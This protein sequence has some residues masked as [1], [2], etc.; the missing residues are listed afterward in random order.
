MFAALRV[1]ALAAVVIVSTT[2]QSAADGTASI[3]GRVV[4][5]RSHKAVT[6][7]KIEL[8]ADAGSSK[9]GYAVAVSQTHSNGDFHVSGLRAGAYKLQVVKMGYAVQEISGL[10][11]DN[12]EHLI[13]GEPVGLVAASAEDMMKMACNSVVRPDATGDVYVVCAGK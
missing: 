4:D 11:L 13:V 2:W 9:N 10:T 5:A 3:S 6:G 7:A 8:F 1:A 12:Q